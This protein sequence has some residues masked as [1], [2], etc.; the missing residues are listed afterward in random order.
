MQVALFLDE[1]PHKR[2]A[3]PKSTRSR[4]T[5]GAAIIKGA[6]TRSG[7][8]RW[9]APHAVADTRVC[10]GAAGMR[11]YWLSG[12][13]RQTAAEFN[14]HAGRNFGRQTFKLSQFNGRLSDAP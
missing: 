7:G 8:S 4:H 3:K 14:L 9:C 13:A 6:G 5:E 1:L 11:R 10:S 2:S 12:R